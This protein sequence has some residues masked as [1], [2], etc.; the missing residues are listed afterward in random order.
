MQ[1]TPLDVIKS[2][3][4]LYVE[5][6]TFIMDEMVRTLQYFFKEVYTAK[7]AEQ[8]LILY[9][10][11][12][13]ISVIITDVVMGQMDGLAFI[14]TIRESDG[15]IPV[16]VLTNYSKEELLMRAVKLKLCDYIIKPV[17]LA[18]LKGGLISCGEELI[19]QGFTRIHLTETLCFDPIDAVLL[20]KEQRI[21]LSRK[22]HRFLM[23]ATRHANT[24][25]S[26]EKI[27]EVVWEGEEMS[28][29]ALRN[30]FNRLRKKIG[31]DKIV[32]VKDFGY[33]LICDDV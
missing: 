12:E 16:L 1:H 13:E 4:V 26:K 9:K 17:S 21:A 15:D 27:E 3:N 7:S 8:A 10:E 5:D 6:D 19:R 14:R 32:T 29:Q 28:E 33:K 2:V 23:L 31:R 30:F 24:L 20:N 22:E 18:S 25:V 11:L